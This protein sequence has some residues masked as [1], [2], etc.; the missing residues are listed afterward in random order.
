MK[1]ANPSFFFF[2]ALI[3]LSANDVRN[4]TNFLLPWC[5]HR[6]K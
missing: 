3:E 1:G 2:F 6:K 5:M 4:V